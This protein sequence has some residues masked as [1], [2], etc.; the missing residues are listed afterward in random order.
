[1]SDIIQSHLPC[2]ECGS[3]DALCLNSDGSTF[4]YS[5]KH[6]TPANEVDKEQLQKLASQSDCGG[7]LV[8]LIPVEDLCF[9]PLVARRIT[10]ETCEHLKYY[11]GMY[12]NKPA[13]IACYYADDGTMCGQKIRC[14]NK[15]FHTTGHISKRF[16]GQHLWSH[17]KKLVI[18]EGEI[19]CLTVSQVTGNKYPVVSVPN[20]CMSIKKCME[21]NLEWLNGFDEV[22]LMLDMDEP[23][24][25]A[26]SSV[27]G[28]LPPGKLMIATLPLKDPNECLLA[29]K[30]GAIVEAI[31]QAKVYK[32][33]GIINGSDLWEELKDEP[34]EDSGYEFPWKDLK[35]QE[36]TRG[37]RKGELLLITA[38]T[39]TGKTTFVRQIAYHMGNHQNLK[40]G[41]M[42][43]EENV[44]RTAKGLMAI[45]TGKRL[46]LNRHLLSDEDYHKAFEETLG[47]GKYVFYQHFGSLES[48]NL[49]NKMRYLATAEKCDFII[50]DHISIAISGLDIEN[51]RKATDVLMTRLRSLAEET[52]VGLLIISHLKR[53]DGQS[54]EEGGIISL[55]HLRGSQALSQLSDCVLALERNQQEKN[56]KK[57]NRVR[58]RVLKNRFTGETGIGGYLFYDKNTDRLEEVSKDEEADVNLSDDEDSPF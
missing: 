40:V 30:A 52:G 4:C 49:I 53:I 29:G 38:G 51:E 36:M 37:I 1:M 6:F 17:G 39:G 7:A 18:T 12:G 5:C 8:D 24:R 32:P 58:I 45:H 57:K 21:A 48:D 22:V 19:D 44:K 3:H 14:A 55:S 34:D 43:L 50:L 2:P 23:G 33:D 42:M 10:K 54:A 11:K 13:Q 16:Y 31:Y 27:V 15:E 46:A 41:M 35:L 47:S 28:L 56:E 20:G 25:K 26:V 9:E